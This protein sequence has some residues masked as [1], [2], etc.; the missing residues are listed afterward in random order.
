MLGSFTL[1]VDCC[2]CKMFVNRYVARLH[3]AVG[4]ESCVVAL[5]VRI[6]LCACSTPHL[7][8]TMCQ[9]STRLSVITQSCHL[10][11]RLA[12]HVLRPLSDLTTSVMLY[13]HSHQV[14]LLIDAF[15]PLSGG[16]ASVTPHDI[17]CTGPPLP[18]CVASIMLLC[19]LRG[20]AAILLCGICYAVQPLSWGLAFIVLLT[21]VRWLWHCYTML[22]VL[23]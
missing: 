2:N 23:C 14:L 12:W 18:E 19:H 16:S 21:M 3:G 5:Y 10:A 9:L 1:W 6:T 15:L 22:L 20:S 8:L 17:C 4:V 11:L 13:C 7:K